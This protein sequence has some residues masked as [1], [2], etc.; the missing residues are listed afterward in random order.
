MKISLLKSFVIGLALAAGPSN[1]LA[2]TTILVKDQACTKGQTVTYADGSKTVAYTNAD[3]EI[4]YLG[5]Y[6]LSKIGYIEVKGAAFVSKGDGTKAQLRVGFLSEGTVTDL[7]ANGINAQSGTIRNN[8]SKLFQITAETTPTALASGKNATQYAGADFIVNATEVKTEGT[9]DGTC[10]LDANNSAVLQK[11][12]GT[13]QL[14]LYGNASSRRLAV[15]EI[16]IHYTGEGKSIE[17]ATATITA[18]TYVRKNNTLNH[19]A[20]T[21]MEIRTTKS[22]AKDDDF[23]G[24]MSFSMPAA[25]V[26][27]V[28]KATLKLVTER[29]KGA[30]SMNIYKYNHDFAESAKYD[31]EASY[32]EEARATTPTP[33]NVAYGVRSNSLVSDDISKGPELSKWTNN[34]DL[35]SLANAETFNILI[36]SGDET[37]S[38]SNKFFSKEATDITNAKNSNYSFASTDL[39]PTLSITYDNSIATKSHILTIGEAKA[40]T[41]MLPYSTTI[42]DGVKCFTLS[43]TSGSSEVNAQ[44][45]TDGTLPANTP[46]LVNAEAGDYTFKATSDVEVLKKA[47]TGSLTGVCAKTTVPEGSYILYNGGSGIGFY[48]VDGTTNTIDANQAYLSA[49]SAQ[50]RALTIN[51]GSTTSINNISKQQPTDDVTYTLQGIRVNGKLNQGIYIQNG[52][53]IIIR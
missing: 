17:T 21:T 40:A 38:Q 20:E 44:E 45:L 35:T 18:D 25:A 34:I 51:Y 11:T 7:T 46:V 13:Y 14:F 28:T 23:V 48:K 47:T 32:I 19:G 42:P 27:K 9:Y 37:S 36:T 2:Q 22:G 39:Q 10:T 5:T 3:N 8:K 49:T 4:W 15:D 16:I 24:L 50:A 12:S 30:T 33:F 1:V 6:D 31:D 29:C 43:Y 26:G 53:K 41:L 52:K